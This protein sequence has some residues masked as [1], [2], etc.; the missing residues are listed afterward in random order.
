MKWF[1]LMHLKIQK[2]NDQQKESS[3]G[4]L[5]IFV[6]RAL[7]YIENVHHREGSITKQ[8]K[9]AAIIC[10]AVALFLPVLG[11]FIS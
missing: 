6:E 2:Q 3:T 8:S 9:S 11:S 5:F 7:T 1:I 10:R 4:T